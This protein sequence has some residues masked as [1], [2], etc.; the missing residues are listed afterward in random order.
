MP[1]PTILAG[2]LIST[3]YGALFHLIRGGS[4]RRFGFY[5]ILAYAGYWGG[6]FLGWYLGWNFVSIGMMNAG[7][8]TLGSWLLLVAGDWVSRIEIKREE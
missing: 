5:L 2:I 7:T 6:E 8:A 4:L 3:L 1:L